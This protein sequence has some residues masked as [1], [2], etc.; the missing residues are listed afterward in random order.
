MRVPATI[1]LALCRFI[2]PQPT[3]VAQLRPLG[4]SSAEPG[5]IQSTGHARHEV[6]NKHAHVLRLLP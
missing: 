4:M 1:P 2:I 6:S 3:A 5:E